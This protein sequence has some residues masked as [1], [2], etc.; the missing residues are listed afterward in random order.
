MKVLFAVSNENISETIIKKYHQEYKEIISGKNVYYFNAILQELQKDKT[1]D[2][3][4]ISEDLEMYAN[5]NYDIIDKFIFDKLGNISYE[6]CNSLEKNIPIIIIC[7]D[8]RERKCNML[9]KMLELGIYNCLVGNDRSLEKVCRLINTPRDENQAI[10]YYGVDIG[11]RESKIN[12]LENVSETEI[13]NILIHYKRLGKNEDKYLESFNSIVTQY[14]DTQ[15]RIIAKFLPVNVR[16]VLEA[17]SP[18]YQQL[19][20]TGSGI[21]MQQNYNFNKVKEKKQVVQP[22]KEVQKDFST[23][24]F[25]EEQLEKKKINS[26]VIIPQANRTVRKVFEENQTTIEAQNNQ[27]NWESMKTQNEEMYGEISQEFKEENE[28]V[29]MNNFE[30]ENI[31]QPKRGRGRPPKNTVIQNQQGQNST[32]APR[33]D[34]DNMNGITNNEYHVKRKRGRPAKNG[35]S[36]E[37]QRDSVDINQNTYDNQG[38]NNFR[39]NPNKQ[40]NIEEV[41]LFELSNEEEPQEIDLFNLSSRPQN[42]SVSMPEIDIEPVDRENRTQQTNVQNDFGQNNSFNRNSQS[43]SMGNNGI[44][45][46]QVQRPI[47]NNINQGQTTSR[48]DMYN[49]GAI[50]NVQDFGYEQGISSFI[51]KDKKVVAF[52]GTSKNGTS[53]V[54]NT[55][56]E[57]FSKQGIKTA[58][59]DLTKNKNAYYIY[60]KNDEN[61]RKTAITCISALKTGE[62]RPIQVN[63]NLSVFTS[64]P[65]NEEEYADYESILKTLVQNYSVILLD[66]D[67]DTELGYIKEAQELYV[68]QSM[69]VL[70]I[71]PLT[72]YLRELKMKKILDENK[73]RIVINKFVRM[74][75]ITEKVIIGGISNYNDPEML[76]MTELFNKDTVKYKTISFDTLTYTKYLEALIDCEIVLNKYSK[77]F[78]MELRELAAMVYPLIGNQRSSKNVQT[79]SSSI[80]STLEKMKNNY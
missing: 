32:A 16:S 6:A 64:L 14:S 20:A 55:L 39:T 58:I 54:V 62:D 8:R 66:C 15:L 67:F 49:T 46:N 50:Q 42:V 63:K 76:F 3:I 79:F 23:P 31:N 53:F 37:F 45:N 59:L 34:I 27:S 68:V 69:D 36:Q 33:V 71:Q 72:E 11:N 52:V 56:A 41:N 7:A 73:L 26:A 80:D 40:S 35:N 57:M 22:K 24:K 75:G 65:N 60:T 28:D 29:N 2:R 48:P 13:Q 10:E 4:V 77:T 19:M 51:T 9:E 61:L 47:H 17:K 25:I 21:E 5:N 30:N 18:K 44:N 1:Y 70:T 43:N 38:Q 74:R 12:D 78:N